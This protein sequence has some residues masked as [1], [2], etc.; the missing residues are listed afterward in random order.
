MDMK[1]R[2]EEKCTLISMFSLHKLIRN[3]FG[4]IP[5]FLHGNFSCVQQAQKIMKSFK[6]FKHSVLDF[7][8]GMQDV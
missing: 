5:F 2:H 8:L 4:N 7:T 3:S 1:A 6:E